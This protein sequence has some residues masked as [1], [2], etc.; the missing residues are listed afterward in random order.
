MS[1]RAE[2]LFG[3]DGVRGTANLHPMTASM[4]LRLGQAAAY[5][6]RGRRD[7]GRRILIA[8]DTR[9]SGYMFEDALAA[10][11]SSMGGTVI[12]VGPIPTPALAFLT[13]DMRCDAGVMIT[14]SHNPYQDN[15]IKF[16]GG[17]GFKLHDDIERRIE[18]LVGSAEIERNLASPDEV[19]PARRIDDAAG[20]YVVFLKN[21]FPK[22][23]SLDGL[24]I[25]LDCA[26]GAGYKVGPLVFQELGAEVFT[27]GVEPDGRNINRECG[28]L[29]PEK[30][31]AKVREL[32]ADVGI[33]LD[34]DADRVVI[35]DE[36]G[37]ILD[38]DILMSLCAE[39]MVERGTLRGGA[40]VATVMSNLGLEKE[41]ARHGVEL[42]RTQVGDRYVVD[43]MRAGG[44][45]LGGEQSGHVVFLDHT[46]TGD[47]LMSALQV[48]GIMVRS[49]KQL[50]EPTGNFERFPQVILNIPVA[51]RVPFEELPS[52]TSAVAKAEA[53]LADRGRVLIR[54]SG[55]ELKARVM[56]EGEDESRVREIAETLADELKRALAAG[57]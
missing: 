10:G 11:I 41:L 44:H 5:V 38:G 30:T 36:K 16:F 32:R 53:A 33:A 35:V 28:S 14:A 1:A 52:L 34:G 25:V 37:A 2:N 3:T 47:G 13:V 17:D 12:Q 50:S 4:A 21:T 57:G 27:L 6:F 18:E 45:N 29:F 46:T 54:Y 9:L 49:G 40:V 22:Q 19:G 26:N 42:V 8:K 24:R 31:A 7:G 51:R 23:H 55:T 15:G 43:A 39:D 20:R 48:L 56:V